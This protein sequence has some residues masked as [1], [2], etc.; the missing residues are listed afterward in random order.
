MRYVPNKGY[1]TE[2]MSMQKVQEIYDMREMIERSLLPNV[3]D[4][5]TVEGIRCLKELLEPTEVGQDDQALNQRLIRDRKFHQLLASFSGRRIPCQML[6]YLFDLLYLKYRGSLLFIHSED[7]MGSQ[8]QRIFE[9]VISHDPD[10]ADK[11][12]QSRVR[13]IKAQAL[14]S[15]GKLMAEKK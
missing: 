2:P 12:L 6:R 9:A 5:L 1:A 14:K 13:Q 7:P 10:E 15:L 3:I 8:H 11:A 4:N